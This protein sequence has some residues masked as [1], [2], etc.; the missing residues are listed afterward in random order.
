MLLANLLAF[1]RLLRRLAR[2]PPG[3]H[4]DV[5][6]A[7]QPSSVRDEV[8]TPAA[9]CSSIAKIAVFD[10]AFEAFWQGRRTKSCAT[11]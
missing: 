1:G 11:T 9:R 3:A 4:A 6:E 2:R 10:R 7:L 5:A 8:T